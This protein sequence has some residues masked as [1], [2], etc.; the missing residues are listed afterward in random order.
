M[1]L[2]ER[3][4]QHAFFDEVSKDGISIH[5]LL[6]IDLHTLPEDEPL[7]N[8]RQFYICR[9]GYS[10]AHTLTWVEQLH[11]AVF[12]L[13]DSSRSKKQLDNGIQRSH[14][15]IYNIENYLVRLQ[16]I[17]DRLLQLVNSVFHICNAETTVSHVLIVNN[18]K[19]ARTE[20]P[21]LLKIVRNTIKHKSEV[22]NEIIHR[23]SYSDT[24]LEKMELL[25]MH[26]KETW[27]PK[28][29]DIT[30]ER[31]CNYRTESMK[32]IVKQKKSEFELINSKLVEKLVPLFNALHVQYQIEK[33]RLDFIV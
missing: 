5:V 29:K 23:H 21:K 10:L 15:L 26:T 30:Y 4:H 32:N 19:V 14:H 28:N 22:R 20:I 3:L 18:L 8:E 33:K 16:S 31:L 13:S 25:Y 1:L 7:M 27:N 17:Y 9:V 24:E 6:G 12:F 11:Q 2:V